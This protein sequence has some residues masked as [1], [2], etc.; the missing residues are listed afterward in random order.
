MYS[1]EKKKCS[2]R[3]RVL[4]R[5][6]KVPTKAKNFDDENST[7]RGVKTSLEQPVKMTEGIWVTIGGSR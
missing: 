7:L 2:L 5:T 6:K 1:H 4:S 3:G